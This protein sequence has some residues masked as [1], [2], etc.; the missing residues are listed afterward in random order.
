MTNVFFLLFVSKACFIIF[1]YSVVHIKK[2]LLAKYRQRNRKIWKNKDHSQFDQEKLFQ[3]NIIIQNQKFLDQKIFEQTN[4][5]LSKASMTS[6]CNQIKFCDTLNKTLEHT[7]HKF[8]NNNMHKIYDMSKFCKEPPW[9]NHTNIEI[10]SIHKVNF[11]AIKLQE[12]ESLFILLLLL[13]LR[14]THHNNNFHK[15]EFYFK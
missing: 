4:K 8:N 3:S 14:I 1:K 13:L 10:I 5:K 2:V 9:K 15:R 12:L 6:V 7:F 11:K